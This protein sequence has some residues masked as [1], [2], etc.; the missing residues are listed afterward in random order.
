MPSLRFDPSLIESVV[1]AAAALDAEL[2]RA[3]HRRANPLYET[4]LLDER[5]TAFDQLHA[6]L[7]VARGYSEW[8][9]ALFAELPALQ[10]RAPSLLVLAARLAPEEGAVVGRDGQSVCL[11]ITPERFAKR[12]PLSAFVRHELR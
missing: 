3:Y 11:R 5:E 6:Q 12:E 9:A 1:T 7:F 8:F 10:Q 2:A 4:L